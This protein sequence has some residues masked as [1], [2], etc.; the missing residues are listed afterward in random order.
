MTAP[1]TIYNASAG[2]GKTFTLA[3]E[4]ITLLIQRPDNFMRTLAVTFT[5][6]A[7]EEMKIRILSNLHGLSRGYSDA[8]AYL[9]HL[10]QRTG[11][12]EAQV[13]ERA[14]QS[15]DLM[16][17]NYSYFRVETIDAFFQTVLRNLAR[18]LELSATMRIDLNQNHQAES[19]AVDTMIE[20]LSESDDIYSSLMSYIR[21]NIDDNKSWNVVSALKEFGRHIFDDRYIESREALTA[22]IEASG[23]N[24]PY[25][26]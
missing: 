22:D 11:L 13:R 17:Q 7:T 21:N 10:M 1:L 9:K 8:D 4:Y 16:M 15:L 18:E 2:S 19:E 20:R 3:L 24:Q 25:S 26:K 6:K 5:N 14:R 12:S 23:G